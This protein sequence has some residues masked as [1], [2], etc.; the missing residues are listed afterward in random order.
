VRPVLA[1]PALDLRS[2]EGDRAP[3]LGL[4]TGAIG[5]RIVK[6]VA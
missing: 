5:F 6:N 3:V 1:R 4:R 2:G